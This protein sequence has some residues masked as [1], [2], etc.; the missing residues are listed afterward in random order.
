MAVE[1]GKNLIAFFGAGNSAAVA[2]AQ[3]PKYTAQAAYNTERG[4]LGNPNQPET[5]V[6][7]LQGDKLYYFA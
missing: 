5:R 7:G 3:A 4:E 1:F 2:N 6:A